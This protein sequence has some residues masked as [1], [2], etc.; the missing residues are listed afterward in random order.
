MYPNSSSVRSPY[1]S[2]AVIPVDTLM[3]LCEGA[4]AVAGQ[5][6][7][8]DVLWTTVDIAVELTGARY[9]ALGIVGE[10]GT[11]TEFLHRG[12]PPGEAAGIGSPPTGRGVL[13]SIA[14][15]GETI[16]TT[17]ITHHPDAVGVPPHH[18]QMETF[19]GVPI[20]AGGTV[21]GNLYLTEKTGGFTEGDETLVE[22]LA[23]IAGSAIGSARLHE[24]MR[25]V[26]VIEDRERIA[27]DIHDG[28]IQDLLAVGLSLQSQAHVMDDAA[29]AEVLAEAT[30]KLDESI[31]SLRSFILRLQPPS[32]SRPT[33]EDRLRSLIAGQAASYDTAVRVAVAPNLG[34]VP[35]QTAED[36]LQVTREALSNA[37]RHSGAPRVDVTIRRTRKALTITVGDHGRGFDLET[38]EKGLGLENLTARTENAGG[39]VDLQSTPGVGTVVQVSLPV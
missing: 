12:L 39:A 17:G 5:T 31:G 1:V 32:G 28:V 18:P 35:S 2:A 4:A 34:E 13:G 37:L 25:R 38:V 3:R 36:A 15:R 27:R 7:L 8:H 19:L 26:V 14:R 11:V 23:V 6:E 22:A 16:R 33:F 24:R 29:V 30:R 9:G 21:Y 10:H 20:R